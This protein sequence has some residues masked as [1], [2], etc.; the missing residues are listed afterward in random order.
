MVFFTYYGHGHDF[1]CKT[2]KLLRLHLEDEFPYLLPF[3]SWKG[4]R[5]SLVWALYET[6]EWD[7]PGT[8]AR[9]EAC[10]LGIQAAQSSI[11]MSSTFFPGDLVMKK[12]LRPISLFLWFKKSSCQLLAKE[13]ALS[14]GKLPRRFGQE[15]RNS[16]VRVTVH[17]RNY[18]KCVEGL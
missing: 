15:V 11:P 14:T 8:V 16:V 1:S 9:S 10:P 12:F 13:S 4:N 18:L 6:T 5:L 3:S 7:S 2:L 17:A